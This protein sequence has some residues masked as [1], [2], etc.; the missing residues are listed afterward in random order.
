M[1]TNKDNEKF[2]DRCYIFSILLL[3]IIINLLLNLLLSL[4]H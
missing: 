3:F 2:K 4:I 1:V